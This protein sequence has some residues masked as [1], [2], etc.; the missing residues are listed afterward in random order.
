MTI[1]VVQARAVHARSIARRMREAD[2]VEVRL[3]SGKTP[4]EALAF[5]LR[6]SDVAFVALK[7]GRPEVMFGVGAINVIAGIGAIWLLGTDEI[8]RNVVRFLRSSVEWRNRL[9]S[10]YPILRNFVHDENV[11]TKR[12]LEWLGAEFTG[13]HLFNGYPFTM[14]EMRA[15]DV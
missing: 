15:D 11:V 13:S 4:F 14:F 7:D 6:K 9:L 2:R 12:W 8:D 10:R 5:S 1:E 3:A